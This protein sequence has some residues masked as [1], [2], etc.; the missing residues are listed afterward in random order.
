MVSFPD[1]NT[2]VK[3]FKNGFFLFKSRPEPI[4]FGGS[5][6]GRFFLSG[7]DLR[8]HGRKLVRILF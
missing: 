3:V 1:K 7:G 6:P 2:F 5:I 4:F 8:S